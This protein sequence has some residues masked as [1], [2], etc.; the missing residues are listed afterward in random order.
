MRILHTSLQ[1]QLSALCWA[2]WCCHRG[3][4]QSRWWKMAFAHYWL[5]RHKINSG[6]FFLNV[7]AVICSKWLWT[8]ILEEKYGIQ[9]V[10]K[11][12][13]WAL[14]IQTNLSGSRYSSSILLLSHARLSWEH[15]SISVWPQSTSALYLS[16]GRQDSL[17]KQL[18]PVSIYLCL[19]I[20]WWQSI[21][22]SL[23]IKLFHFIAR[24]V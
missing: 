3:P 17:K 8:S 23:L 6:L 22:S 1:P 11:S 2:C 4:M 20:F 18:Y 9:L 21:K 15:E 16:K 5:H 14:K 7:L 12:L 10:L 24:T 19:H 13:S